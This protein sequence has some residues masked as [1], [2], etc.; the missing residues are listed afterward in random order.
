MVPVGALSDQFHGMLT[1]NDTG[2]FLF[3]RLQ[4]PTTV[5]ALAAAILENY[6]GVDQSGA[7]AAV[8]RFL[9]KLSAAGCLE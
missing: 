3:E 7:E 5:Q 9:E 6:D 2:A 1:L 4:Q 8:E